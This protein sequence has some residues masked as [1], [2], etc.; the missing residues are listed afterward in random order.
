[1]RTN[2]SINMAGIVEDDQGKDYL[3][4]KARKDPDMPNLK[5]PMNSDDA[6][7]WELAMDDE[8]L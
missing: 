8:L 1:M 7:K 4:F 3:V 5:Q 6:Q 2:L